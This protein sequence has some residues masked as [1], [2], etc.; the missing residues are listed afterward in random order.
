M[1]EK[2]Q[3][4]YMQT[5][6]LRLASE[7]WNR[8]MEEIAEIFD[9]YQVLQY[10]EECFGI[11]HVQGDEAILEDIGRYLKNREMIANAGIDG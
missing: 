1:N 7:E 11:F 5:R 9:R 3:L 2:Q 8:P 6:V 4:L 10:I